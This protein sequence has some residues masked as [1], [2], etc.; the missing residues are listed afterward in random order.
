MQV[1]FQFLLVLHSLS[2]ILVR[3]FLKVMMHS[4]LLATLLVRCAEELVLE[5]A[6]ACLPRLCVDMQHLPWQQGARPLPL[7]A[8]ELGPNFS[9]LLHVLG[10]GPRS[11][12]LASP[13]VAA[14]LPLIS[15]RR[16]LATA[17]GSMWLL[18]Y[19]ALRRPMAACWSSFFNA[20]RLMKVHTRVESSPKVVF[21]LWRTNFASSTRLWKLRGESCC[22]PSMR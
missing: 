4:K 21:G 2:P 8:S 5:I 12:P 3:L 20:E 22:V 16:P 6:M 14:C 15:C 18:A 11:R 7:G 1:R 19:P 17:T 9:R 10:T 13:R